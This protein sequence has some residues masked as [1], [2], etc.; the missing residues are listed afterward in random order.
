MATLKQKLVVRKILENNGNVS[1]SMREVGYAANYAKNPQDLVETKG[2]KQVMA[3][4]GLTEELITT[5]LVDDIKAKPKKRFLELSLGS[6][7]LGMKKR[8]EPEN[9]KTPHMTV[10]N[11]IVPN[12]SAN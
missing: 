2:F 8:A 5:A 4:Y 11:L 6:E 7:I 9:D 12:G 1:K 10:I 3:S